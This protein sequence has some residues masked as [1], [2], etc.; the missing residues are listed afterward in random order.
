M[1]LADA[2]PS[3][4]SGAFPGQRALITPE[5]VALPVM[6]ADRGERAAA[7]LIDLCIMGVG[8]VVLVAL[9]I[10]ALAGGGFSA[11]MLSLGLVISFAIRSFYFIFFEL[12]WQGVTPG[13]RLIG[14]RV[15]DRNGARL[16][17]DAIFARNL[18]REVEIF[19][20]VT[21]LLSGDALGLGTWG[22]LLT[23]VWLSV[24]VCLP[25]FNK[26][27]LR[28]GDLAGGTW[29]VVAPKAVL[30]PDVAE[31]PA[32]HLPAAQRQSATR[33]EPG[34]HFTK[35]QL[36]VYGIYELQTLESVLRASGPNARQT[37]SAVAA[38]IQRKIGWKTE[39]T[40]GP[41]VFLRAFY[42]AL[43]AHLEAKMLFG[44]RREN[45]YD[46]RP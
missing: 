22:Y 19:L 8:I 6:L 21:V 27:R 9:L 34:V 7:L 3:G 20:P 4:R 11:S 23:L 39:G 17:S 28:A 2:K 1:T 35:A 14:I 16:T 12:R 45:K 36:D 29:V 32:R 26:D 38:R 40:T 13:K 15:I 46:R 44:V 31:A 41:E 33:Q 24:F 37:Q 25:F 43:R 10:A 42:T 18:M 5:G 30:R